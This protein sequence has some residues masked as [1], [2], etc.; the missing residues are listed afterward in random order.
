MQFGTAFECVVIVKYK[1]I[2]AMK[3]IL[4]VLAIV[5]ACLQV[6]AQRGG[7]HGGNS[8]G[9]GGYH[10]GYG[11]GFHGGYGGG[12]HGGYGE[13]FYGG[14][15]YGGFYHGYYPYWGYGFG[16]GLGLGLGYPYY[17]YGYYPYNYP[18]DY[19]Y[20]EAPYAPGYEPGNQ[21]GDE[22][23]SGGGSTQQPPAN[24][25]PAPLVKVYRA[26]SA[27]DLDNALASLRHKDKDE[28]KIIIAKQIIDNNY[29]FTYQVK[30]IM[31]RFKDDSGRLEVAEYAYNRCL[32]RKNYYILNSTFKDGANVA[33]L[34]SYMK[35][36]K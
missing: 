15:G 32:D 5:F 8:H 17:G 18:Y 2:K 13:H 14:R 31:G 7:G 10:G 33:A 30:E 24:N 28:T 26:I 25:N 23:S 27:E 3:R 4:I 6:N 19:G 21:S 34:D 22:N 36:N 16:L 9:G 35:A 1:K 11:G 12:F 29:F 20:N